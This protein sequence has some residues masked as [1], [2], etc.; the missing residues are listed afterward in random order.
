MKKQN[1]LTVILIISIA[2]IL[3]SGYLSFAEL[4]AGSC[5][6]GGCSNLLG[7]PVCVYGLIMY[8]IVFIFSLIG[9]GSK[10]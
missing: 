7:L 3:F 10:K 5:P 6:L 9:L 2:G 8:I 1:A 4:F